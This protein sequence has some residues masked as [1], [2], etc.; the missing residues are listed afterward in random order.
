MV[1]R[2]FSQTSSI[3]SSVRFS[4][5]QI[6]GNYLP[7]FG[8]SKSVHFSKRLT[9][10]RTTHLNKY[11]KWYYCCV[12]RSFEFFDEILKKKDFLKIINLYICDIYEQQE[13]KC[14]QSYTLRIVKFN[15]VWKRLDKFRP[16]L[17]SLDQFEHV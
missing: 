8:A 13:W 11:S 16:I 9:F 15:Q 2:T 10:F 3:L 7:K 4:L 12:E 14:L 1:M 5:T 6:K 17:T